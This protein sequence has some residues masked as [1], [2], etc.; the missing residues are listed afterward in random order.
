[1]THL[2]LEDMA[3]RDGFTGAVGLAQDQ[4]WTELALS[5]NRWRDALIAAGA[6]SAAL[7]FEN[8]FTFTAALLGAWAAGC[9]AVIAGDATAATVASLSPM[10]DAFLGG[11][12]TRAD[13][14]REPP[15]ASVAEPG[16]FPAVPV[17][18][19]TSGS[20]GAPV[21]VAKSVPDLR[22]ELDTL[23]TVFGPGLGSARVLSTVS[24][25]HI[26]GLLFRCLWPLSRGRPFAADQIRYP[27]ELAERIAH[28]GPTALVASPAF[29]RRLPEAPALA[30]KRLPLSAVFSSG[31][32]LPWAAASGSE[33]LFGVT[34]FE[35]YG[36]SETGGIAWRP[37]TSEDRAWAPFPGVGISVGPEGET[38]LTASPHVSQGLPMSLS[39]RV[40]RLGSDG[41]GFRLLG[42]NDRIVKLEEKRLSLTA[43]EAALQAHPRVA[44]ARL[45]VLAGERE[46][47]GAV[48]LLKG[49]DIP[50]RGSD[51]RA[52]LVKSLRDH[53]LKGFE[54]VLLPKRWRLV[55]AM[56]QNA[57]GKA[58]Q[59]D[60]ERLFEPQTGPVI[61]AERDQGD[62]T[63]TLDLA[64]PAELE[65]F[66]GHFPQ[67]PL[68]PGVVQLDWAI[69]EG[70]RLFGPFG[71]FRGL[72]ALKFQRPIFP[73]TR[74]RL[75][76]SRLNGKPGVGFRYDSDEGRHASGQALFES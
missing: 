54:R 20:T 4:G 67:L 34:P 10:A 76:I 60:L 53:L 70:M 74:I 42:R 66:R 29:L 52:A 39:D 56:P 62:G 37:R 57:A 6:R 71:P 33:G 58:A 40:E 5:R 75:E 21:A 72:Q 22:N 14:W 55:E 24:H 61:V 18:I 19:F 46:T 73:G 3:L 63:V 65:H 9:T 17:I 36:S 51:A 49:G 13:A 25:Q 48:L 30:G 45:A 69:R 7:H 38:V 27:E 26:Y 2:N 11:F 64:I 8:T 43:M 15:P 47:L 68:L 28:P 1:M 44:E 41:S 50:V 59:A 32:P 16:P 12:P 35:I 23:E 31:G